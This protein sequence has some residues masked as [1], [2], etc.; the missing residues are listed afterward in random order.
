MGDWLGTGHFP[1]KNRVFRPFEAA[2]TF[3]RALGL[4]SLSEWERWSKGEIQGKGSRPHDIPGDPRR[5][6]QGKGWKGYADWLGFVDT[7]LPFQA[8]RAFVRR[9][10]LKSAVEW[11]DYAAGRRADLG[12]RPKDIPAGPPKSYGAEWVSWYDWLGTEAK[13]MRP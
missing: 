5:A 3:V 9:L 12:T 2:R 6:Y 7:P 4:G 11:R 1:T 8:A 13:G 10:G